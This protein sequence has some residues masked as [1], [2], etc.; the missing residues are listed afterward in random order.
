MWFGIEDIESCLGIGRYDGAVVLVDYGD[1]WLNVGQS[2]LGYVGGGGEWE[3]GEYAE[4]DGKHIRRLSKKNIEYVG[5]CMILKRE[6]SIW[7]LLLLFIILNHFILLY[8]I[9]FTF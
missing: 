9:I 6:L 3:E 7:K 8:F 2:G 1:A 5:T 4:K